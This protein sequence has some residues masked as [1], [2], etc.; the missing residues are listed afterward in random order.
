MHRNVT[1]SVRVGRSSDTSSES[2]V[3]TPAVALTGSGDQ[4]AAITFTEQP[5]GA[6]SWRGRG[7]MDDEGVLI[8]NPIEQLQRLLQDR[9][10]YHA[11]DFDA[12]T[13]LTP[14]AGQAASPTPGDLLLPAE[15]WRWEVAAIEA[16]VKG[17]EERM[18]RA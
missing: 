12:T 15:H 18:Q 13:L 9:A 4:V 6:V 2:T 11:E 16:S 5:A 1:V 7:R 10:G 8:T 3:T 14:P 17:D